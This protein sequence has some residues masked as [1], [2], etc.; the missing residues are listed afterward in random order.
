MQQSHRN[1]QRMTA[2]TRGLIET[3]LGMLQTFTSYAATTT[4]IGYHGS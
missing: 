1:E 3:L 2:P 4:V